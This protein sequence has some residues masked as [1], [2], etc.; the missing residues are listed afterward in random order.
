MPLFEV[1]VITKPSK[2]ESEEG[3]QEGLI[4]P[5][6][7]VVAK[8]KQ[9]AIVKVLASQDVPKFDPDRSEVIVRPFVTA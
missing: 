4:L 7:C 3:G 5:P 1:A 6:R 9:S 8:D 2:K